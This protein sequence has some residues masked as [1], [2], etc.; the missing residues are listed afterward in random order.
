MRDPLA[1]TQHVLAQNIKAG[2]KFVHGRG[3]K[4]WTAT[5]DADTT[6]MRRHTLSGELLVA[7]SVSFRGTPQG[8]P[9]SVPLDKIV[10]LISEGESK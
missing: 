6:D 5:S 8:V 1:P 9:L 2:Q 3:G 10:R 4:H 7:V